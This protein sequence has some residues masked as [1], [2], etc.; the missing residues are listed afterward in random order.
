MPNKYKYIDPEYIYTDPE[1]G[2]LRNLA[3]VADH[4][5]LTIVETGATT[6]RAKELQENP[7]KIKNSA[8]LLDI[9]RHLFQDVYSWAGKV[10]TVEIS[11]GGMPFFPVKRFNNAFSFIDGL[12]SEYRR[13]DRKNKSKSAHKLAEIL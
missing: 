11:K 5:T 7:L 8:T 1:T 13:I 9:H 3:G 12:I 6:K 4:N 2:V 10:R